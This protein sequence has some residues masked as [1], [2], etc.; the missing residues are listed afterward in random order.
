MA[1]HLQDLAII[2]VVMTLSHLLLGFALCDFLLGFISLAVPF[3]QKLLGRLFISCT[4]RVK[5]TAAVRSTVFILGGLYPNGLDL[6]CTIRSLYFCFLICNSC[7]LQVIALIH[8][9]GNIITIGYICAFQL[10][11]L[12]GIISPGIILCSI[13]VVLCH[14]SCLDQ[15]DRRLLVY[16]YIFVISGSL[17]KGKNIISG[18]INRGFVFTQQSS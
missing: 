16:T 2:Q 3:I 10:I 14:G 12:V 18:S 4:I 9:A 5:N 11:S 17:I 15:C 8:T 7:Q 6:Y 1:D 13:A